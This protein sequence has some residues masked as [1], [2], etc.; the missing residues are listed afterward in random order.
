MITAKPA[1]TSLPPSCSARAYV[2]W[3]AGVRAEPK[4]A[5]AGPSSA[6]APKPS[7]NSAW[8]RSTRHG[9]ACTQSVGP[10]ES[11]SRW[12]V[13]LPSTWS[14]RW[15]TGPL[16]FDLTISVSQSLSCAL[17]ALDV[18]HG[19]VLLLLVG[20]HRV[21][22][23]EVDRG[24]A[25]AREACHVGPAE[26]RVDLATHRLDERLGRRQVQPGQRARARCR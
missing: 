24:D 8:M 25:E 26:L 2:G 9:S 23:A 21:A 7:T 16:D 6:S 12:S 3:S 15:M 11:S 14:R 1:S 19:H 5:I 13:V 17:A 20:E 18:L 4:T 10:R 22:G